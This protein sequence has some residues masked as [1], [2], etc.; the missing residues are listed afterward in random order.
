MRQWEKAIQHY[1][2]IL[3]EHPTESSTT[4]PE[5]KKAKARLKEAT[6]GVYDLQSLYNESNTPDG[7]VVLI[8]AADYTGP[9][10]VERIPGKGM[11]AWAQYL[12]H[13]SGTI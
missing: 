8:D 12:V 10:K 13:N 5:L 9:V 11:S 3:K 4:Q 6:T 2:S 7:R 1:E